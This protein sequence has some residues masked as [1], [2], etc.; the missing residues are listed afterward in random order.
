MPKCQY[1]K[2]DTKIIKNTEVNSPLPDKIQKWPFCS[3]E[4][5]ILKL[6]HVL[7]WGGD[8]LLKC[9]GDINKCQLQTP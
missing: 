7:V 4:K 9:S 8:K 3:H 2:I 6:E 1:Y 5:S